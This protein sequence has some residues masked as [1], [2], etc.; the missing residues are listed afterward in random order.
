M[1][2]L[3]GM[4]AGMQSEDESFLLHEADTTQVHPVG[5]GCF[6]GSWLADNSKDVTYALARMPVLYLIVWLVLLLV[7][8]PEYFPE[9]VRTII[10][11]YFGYALPRFFVIL[12]AGFVACIKCI[13]RNNGAALFVASVISYQPSGSVDTYLSCCDLTHM[14]P[15]LFPAYGRG[16]LALADHGG[17]E[18]QPDRIYRRKACCDLLH[19][20]GAD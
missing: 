14:Q 10:F 5:N 3:G 4:G 17:A 13:K 18:R 9:K 8:G 15:R 11:L 6:S 2:K 1:S 16:R 19:I 20:H 12:S 7:I